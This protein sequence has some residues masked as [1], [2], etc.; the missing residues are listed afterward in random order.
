MGEVSFMQPLQPPRASEVP[1]Q[2]SQP[3]SER[4]IAGK[5]NN[6]E[7]DG[8]EDLEPND[9]ESMLLLEGIL[10]IYE[11]PFPA[12]RSSPLPATISAFSASSDGN[13]QVATGN[14]QRATW[15]DLIDVDTA[16]SR[17]D[18]EGAFGCN[19]ANGN[20][21]N[22]MRNAKVEEAQKPMQKQKAE[23]Y[24]MLKAEDGL[25]AIHDII[26]CDSIL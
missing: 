25:R 15:Q 11:T 6:E 1:S 2:T 10:E 8:A 7:L 13:G 18:M 26:R 21:T 16:F 23:P 19:D 22:Y 17:T 24:N 4:V 3:K 5:L 14:G 20:I 9:A 12:G